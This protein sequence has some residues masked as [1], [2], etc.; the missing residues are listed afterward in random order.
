[1]MSEVETITEKA[2]KLSSP[3][4]AC[5]AEILLESLDF[6]EDFPISEQWQRE[7]MKRCNE[8]DNGNVE[9]LSG[10]MAMTSLREKYL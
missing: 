6:E 4:R 3:A 9:W 1:M 2:L 8:I 5:I 10:E 7:I